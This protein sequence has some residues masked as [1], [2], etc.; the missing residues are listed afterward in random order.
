MDAAIVERMPVAAW[1]AVH[2]QLSHVE[3][4]AMRYHLGISSEMSNPMGTRTADRTTR[5]PAVAGQFYPADPDR[6]RAEVSMLLARLPRR[7]R[8]AARRR[9][10]LP[11]PATAIP[12][13]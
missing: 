7:P 6:L 12:A 10:S 9:L 5:P 11:T 13:R 8:A 3:T 1:H 4:S 2:G